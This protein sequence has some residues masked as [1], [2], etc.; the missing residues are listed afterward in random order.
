MIALLLIL[1]AEVAAAPSAPP[2]LVSLLRAKD[3]ALLDAIAPGDR[4]V[5]DRTLTPEAIYVDEEGHTFTRAEFLAELRPLPSGVSG[6]I[7]IADFQV[8]R[9]GDTVLVV[10]RDEERENF[11]GHQ[12]QATY[13]MTDT[14][15]Q[16]N[17]EWQLAMVHV[18][19]MNGDPPA[20]TLSPAKLD[21][22]VGRYTAGPDLV[23]IIRREGDHLV[24][25][26][27]G[28]TPKPLLVEIQDV[29][30]IAG[31]PRVRR[32]FERDA[33]GHVIG[34]VDRRETED[35]RWVRAP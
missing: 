35:I 26:R 14:W 6:Q 21:Q 18:H 29:L 22:Y 23:W 28:G 33:Q 11:H 1:A 2:D 12:L 15:V 8:H 7:T 4:A 27:K 30:F 3:Q 16:R 25:G 10:H 24:G 34:F 31:Q 17:G 13:L 19:V 9:V 20:I 5:W 32:L